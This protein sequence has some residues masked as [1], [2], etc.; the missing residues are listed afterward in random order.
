M[1]LYWISF[2]NYL[3]VVVVLTSFTVWMSIKAF[4]LPSGE[5]LTECTAELGALSTAQSSRVLQALCHSRS[6]SLGRGAHGD[7]SCFFLV[8]ALIIHSPQD[9]LSRGVPD[10]ICESAD[11]FKTPKSGVKIMLFLV[12]EAP[13]TSEVF[14]HTE[15]C[16]VPEEA[17]PD[18]KNPL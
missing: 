3:V 6:E 18:Q 11:G 13:F 16:S 5:R 17:R 15:A 2:P 8:F 9:R 1:H 14:I 10:L 4:P 12:S 7:F